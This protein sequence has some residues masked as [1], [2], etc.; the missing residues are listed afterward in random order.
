MMN[1]GPKRINSQAE[2]GGDEPEALRK[3]FIGGLT[4]NT[5]EDELKTFYG[6][7]GDIV[8]VVVMKDGQTKR[9]RGFGFITYA[10]SGSVDEAMKHRP[11]TIDGKQVDPKRAVPR[12]KS[13]IPEAQVSVKKLFVSG[14]KESHTVEQF[15]DYFSKF[16]TVEEVDIIEDKTSGKRRGFAFI[17]FDDFD[18]VDKLSLLR[19]HEIGGHRCD[20]KKGLSREEMRR[21]QERQFR[22]QHYGQGGGYGW[23][24]GPMGYGGYDNY[25]IGYG[26]YHGGY[27]GWGQSAWSHGGFPPGYGPPVPGG[28]AG[29]YG[30]GSYGNNNNY[31]YGRR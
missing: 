6:K 10:K 19:S 11:H 3:L 28:S 22:G 21:V 23:G 1:T 12:E 14:V 8:D 20:V 29:Y 27:G 13:G 25:G 31:G 16:G 18:P 5:G 15:K 30:Y 26:S 4:V 17:T 9:S 2:S 7:W 24:W